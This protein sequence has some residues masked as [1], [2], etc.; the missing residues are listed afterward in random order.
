MAY[1]RSFWKKPRFLWILATAPGYIIGWLLANIKTIFTWPQPLNNFLGYDLL[2]DIAGITGGLITAILQYIVLKRWL[3]GAWWWIVPAIITTAASFS[4]ASAWSIMVLVVLLQMMILI[5]NH[6][7]QDSTSWAIWAMISWSL[8][9]TFREIQFP[10]WFYE[11]A[12]N[13]L[14][15]II[16]GILTGGGLNDLF[17]QQQHA[18]NTTPTYSGFNGFFKKKFHT[19]YGFIKLRQAIR[20][21]H[22][23]K[24]KKISR[25]KIT[26]NMACQR[27][28][29]ANK[30]LNTSDKI[31][32]QWGLTL[33]ELAKLS[34]GTEADR[35][36]NQ[37]YKKLQ[38]SFELNPYQYQ[39]LCIWGNTLTQQAIRIG[40][41]ASDLLFSKAYE[42]FSAAYLI[43]PRPYPIMCN[44]GI[45]LL[46]HGSQ[47]VGPE[48]TRLLNEAC[49]K[50]ETVLK[51]KPRLY[52]TINYW[53]YTIIEQAK[54]SNPWEGEQL[55]AKA[56]EKF[57][58]AYKFKPRYPESHI[59]LGVLFIQQASMKLPGSEET[60]NLYNEAHNRFM[61]AES[62][63]PGSAAYYLAKLSL[64]SGQKTD[65][66]EWLDKARK[67]K[68]LP[69]VQE[70]ITDPVWLSVRECEWF[71]EFLT[72]GGMKLKE[73]Q[74]K[75]V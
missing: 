73:T 48:S 31:L 60:I 67:Y 7:S 30:L 1:I 72:Y 75:L 9:I 64:L 12:V 28:E 65:C 45:A 59:N 32:S 41:E 34:S 51:R 29:I 61:K 33:I 47:K 17:A 13:I 53:G 27:Y 10:A 69:Q 16:V 52:E 57:K 68:A 14:Y 21:S 39:M 2:F 49:E 37:A 18:R 43:K 35:I 5:F 62:L 22:I 74:R 40:G 70:I 46:K 50:F 25:K 20:L 71:K 58:R 44:W 42:K 66:L 6:R 11:F 54:R 56:H 55:L 23:A 24:R 38:A 3:D 4:G 36:L 19:I 15:A 26:Y 8:S 63:Q